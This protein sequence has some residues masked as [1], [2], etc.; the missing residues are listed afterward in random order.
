M[1]SEVQS[2]ETREEEIRVTHKKNEEEEDPPRTQLKH[3]LV[4]VLSRRQ[5]QSQEGREA[6]HIQ[7]SS[8]HV[9]NTEKT[10]KQNQKRGVTSTSTSRGSIASL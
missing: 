2:E 3:E 6:K 4:T 7:L 5:S 1:Q 9:W 10:R 8:V